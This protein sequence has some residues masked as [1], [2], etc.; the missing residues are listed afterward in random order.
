MREEAKPISKPKRPPGRPT[1]PQNVEELILRLARETGWGYARIQGELKKLG[2]TVAANTIKKVLIKNGPWV[3]QQARNFVMEL[4]DRGETATHL[5][6]EGDTKLTEKFD[7]IFRS[8]GS[9]VKRLPFASPNLNAYAE[10]FVQSAQNECLGHFVAFGERHLKYLLREHEDRYNTVRPH[11]G[12]GNR[13]IGQLRCRSIPPRPIPARLSATPGWEGCCGATA[14][15]PN[16]ALTLAPRGITDKLRKSE[17]EP[18]LC[19]GRNGSFKS[20][21]GL[22]IRIPELTA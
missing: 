7:E 9:K 13:T 15:K 6:K 2:S 19:I 16:E 22:G 17:S 18:N 12:I 10:R 20:F 1:I 3:E 5:I 21:E 14:V 4:T 8:E 11:Q